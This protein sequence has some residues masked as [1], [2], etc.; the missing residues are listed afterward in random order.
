MPPSPAPC[1]FLLKLSLQSEGC[2]PPLCLFCVLVVLHT[3]KLPH[4]AFPKVAFIHYCA[5]SVPM[6]L[7]ACIFIMDLTSA[8]WEL[9][10]LLNVSSPLPYCNTPKNRDCSFLS[11]PSQH[12]T[13]CLAYIKYPLILLIAL[14]FMPPLSQ[15][16]KGG[17]AFSL[18]CIL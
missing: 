7:P 9:L 5:P 17:V 6:L 18:L 13:W 10:F 15:I 3:Q 4:E 16:Q 14:N 1:L 8:G 11:H 2:S 12:E